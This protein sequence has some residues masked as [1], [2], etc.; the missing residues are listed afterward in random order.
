MR[1]ISLQIDNHEDWVFYWRV[2]QLINEGL[3]VEIGLPDGRLLVVLPEQKYK[4][5]IEDPTK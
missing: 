3:P 1:F 5:L 2:E 4:E